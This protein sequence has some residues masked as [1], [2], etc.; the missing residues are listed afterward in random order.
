MNFFQKLGVYKTNPLIESRVTSI[1]GHGWNPVKVY[2]AY[3]QPGVGTIRYRVE[4]KRSRLVPFIRILILKYVLLPT[5][6]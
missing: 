5:R 6:L 3:A 2:V 4:D 1:L